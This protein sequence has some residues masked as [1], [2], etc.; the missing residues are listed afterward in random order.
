[1]YT[2]KARFLRHCI[3]ESLAHVFVPANRVCFPTPRPREQS[4]QPWSSER[5]SK[6]SGPAE[7][8]EP[9]FQICH[10]QQSKLK[11]KQE[12]EG[13]SRCIL[14]L[15]L[16]NP[17][18]PLL[19]RNVQQLKVPPMVKRPSTITRQQQ[20]HRHTRNRNQVQR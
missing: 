2:F 7:E 11:R 10:R 1:M 9:P 17:L 6:E 19:F 13:N 3:P 18:L 15:P 5:T 8:A 12:G 4:R 16:A 20:K 14:K